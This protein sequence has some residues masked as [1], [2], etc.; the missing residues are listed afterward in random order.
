MSDITASEC[1]AAIN[2]AMKASLE[3]GVPMTIAI[4]D[5]GRNLLAFLRMDGALL[6]TIEIAQSKA[7]TARTVNMRTSVIG[8]LVQPGQPLFG[9][10]TTHRNPLTVF[11]GGVPVTRNG[12]VVGAVGA[13]GGSVEQDEVIADVA[14]GVLEAS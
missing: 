7:Y 5:A 1:Q 13:S 8:P 10:E 12:K 2:A 4:V 9:L 14:V 3:M 6:G 11:G